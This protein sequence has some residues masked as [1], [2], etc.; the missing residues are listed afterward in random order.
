MMLGKLEDI[1]NHNERPMRPTLVHM[2]RL[3]DMIVPEPQVYI[4]VVFKQRYCD[5]LT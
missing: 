2:S 3:A 5:V 4:L 1:R